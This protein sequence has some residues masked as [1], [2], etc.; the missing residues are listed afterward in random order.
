VFAIA[1]LS[2]SV[3]A[4]YVGSVFLY[5]LYM[6]VAMMIGSPLMA[7]STSQ[8]PDAMALAA[9]LDP[10]GISAFF[11]QTWYWTPAQRNTELL[12]LSGYFLLNRLLVLTIAA[13]VLAITYR[14]FSFRVPASVRPNAAPRE[15]VLAPG[16]QYRAVAGS[17]RVPA[18]L[19]ALRVATFQEFRTTVLSKS[20]VALLALWVCVAVISVTQE[21][22]R[23]YGTRMYPTAGVMIDANQIPLLFLATLMLV[24]FASDVMWR[25]R[26]LK[27][28]EI[29]DATPAPSGV[30]YLAKGAALVLLSFLMILVPI[31]VGLG[32]QLLNGFTTLQPGVYLS[33]FYYVGLPLVLFTVVVMLVQTVVSN[34]YLGVLVAMMVG[35]VMM[36]PDEL[37]LSHGLLR[38][39]APP[40]A[41]YT[42]MN[43]FLAPGVFGVY[44][45]YWAGLAGVLG[46]I[47]LGLWRRGRAQSLVR[48]VRRLPRRL[49]ARGAAG[50]AFSAAVFLVTGSFIFYNTNIRVRYETTKQS[51]DRRAEYERRYRHYETL[52]RPSIT[53]VRTQ[54]ELYP[55]ERRYKISGSYRLEN[56]SGRAIDTVLLS[57]PW[58]IEAELMELGG[59]SIVRYDSATGVYLFAYARPLAP[60]GVAEV[61]FRIASPPQAI[62]ARAFSYAVVKNGSFLM[63]P[64]AFPRLGYVIGKEIADPYQRRARGLGLPRE[65]LGLVN[66]PARDD[67]RD[68]WL[69]LDATVSTEED[70][71]ALAPGTLLREWRSSGRHYYQYRTDQP[72]TPMFGFLSARYAVQR[73]THHGV[74]VEVYHDPRH[75]YNVRKMFAVASRSLD[76][77][78]ERFG[79]YPLKYLRI[80][81][82]PGHW[83]FGAYAMSG[84][85]VWPEDRGFLTDQSRGGQVDLI[86]RRTAHEVSHQWWGHQLYPA[87]VEGS[88]MLVETLAKYSEMLMLEA[89]GGKASLPPL[90]RYERDRYLMSRANVRLP[91]PPLSQVVDLEYVYY[92]KGAIVMEAIRDLIGEGAL[93]RALRRL[94][95]EH[96]ASGSPARA[97]DLLDALRAESTPEAYA[98]IEEWLTKVS[99]VDLRVEDA[100]AETLPGG[101]YRV[102]VTVRG[103]KTL[104]PGGNVTPT[105]VPL[106]EQIDVAVYAE[107]PLTRNAVPVYAGKHRIHSGETRLTFEVSSRPAFI[108]LDPFERRIELERADNVRSITMRAGQ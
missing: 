95:R 24:Y 44:M 91:E 3:L 43:G 93:D 42:E 98:L 28:D 22:I 27:L 2:R 72:I 69:T 75:S 4:S 73:V 34:R 58:Q 10:F 8:S 1:V 14:R 25:E 64:D 96:D 53:L 106:D 11:Q 90:L 105:V 104:D 67:Y 35:L 87:Q 77:F 40:K 79:P 68:G 29:I 17:R 61:R 100:T 56:R 12:S 5:M 82:L 78:S 15:E 88:A 52:P 60:G 84:M 23:E 62:V 94:L 59:A 101:R 54:V 51:M 74:S 103:R 41:P 107:N 70:Q 19:A 20:F 7:G 76:M 45:V 6:V 16:R 108:S 85:I 48:R 71:V 31:A 92:S 50:V 26:I 102:T 89:M 63:R 46:V 9:L 47:T 33:L 18:R 57:L 97:Q 55:S 32:Y 81:E 37:G 80:A 38:F 21:P 36:N 39:A 49:G 86:T 65:G 30:F 99:F 66:D 13:A 83:E